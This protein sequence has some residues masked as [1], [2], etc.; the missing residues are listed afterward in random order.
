MMKVRCLEK[1]RNKN[2][3]I[4]GYTLQNQLGEI[5]QATPQQVRVEL[6]GEVY[7]FT[8]LQL[9]KAGRI[10]DKNPK[11]ISEF[12]TKKPKQTKPTNQTKQTNPTNQINKETTSETQNKLVESIR[13]RIKK[14][15]NASI[16]YVKG[17]EDDT[18]FPVDEF[19]MNYTGINKYG[20]TIESNMSDEVKTYFTNIVESIRDEV[21]KHPIVVYRC[22]YDDFSAK[23]S[24][25]A[26]DFIQKSGCEWLREALFNLINY[27]DEV[28][29]EMGE[30]TMS[31]GFV[32]SLIRST[33]E[34]K[35]VKPYIMNIVEENAYNEELDTIEW[36]TK[37]EYD[38]AESYSR[39][40]ELV[41]CDFVK[42][43]LGR[44]PEYY[45]K[46]VIEEVDLYL[47]QCYGNNYKNNIDNSIISC[48]SD[49]AEELF[50]TKEYGR[51][52]LAM[53]T[54]KV[55]PRNDAIDYEKHRYNS[56]TEA[57]TFEAINSLK[58]TV[59]RY[60]LDI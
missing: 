50:S 32:G 45:L 41:I 9:D 5:I 22:D 23:L 39:L 16:E 11:S 6:Q 7:N 21:K 49:Y 54:K 55:L 36:L 17:I 59:R 34:Y 31:E 42:D 15:C 1:H 8:N 2:G 57:S 47:L 60:L 19:I 53:N 29:L 27:K 20:E 58:K 44:T 56:K 52:A 28:I 10:I 30:E 38:F 25:P 40:G 48:C 24:V 37:H 13:N 51:R 3:V 26:E 14:A 35:E 18:T 46:L 43:V 12:N 33:S 4:I